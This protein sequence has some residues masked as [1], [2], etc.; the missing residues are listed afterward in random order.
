MGAWLAT[1]L[2]RHNKNQDNNYRCIHSYFKLTWWYATIMSM[3]AQ[4][5]NYWYFTCE[6]NSSTASHT[7]SLNPGSAQFS[8]YRGG[9]TLPC[10]PTVGLMTLILFSKDVLIEVLILST[11]LPLPTATPMD[12]ELTWLVRKRAVQ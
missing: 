3:I 8:V 5:L 9:H 6:F 10:F 7:P 2:I 1:P 12:M 11:T 4:L